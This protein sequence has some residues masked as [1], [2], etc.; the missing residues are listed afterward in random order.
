MV[1]VR[2]V[3][4][5]YSSASGM[6]RSFA[7]RLG[8]EVFD[9]GDRAVRRSVP[10]GPWVLLTPSYTTGNV[11]NDTIP[12]PVRRFLVHPVARRR[13]VGV[14]GSGNRNFGEHYQAACRQIA[15]ASGRPVLFEFELQGTT[16]D[17]EEARRVLEELDLAL[18]LAHARRRT[19]AQA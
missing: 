11:D 13:L 4:Y 14:M 1:P 9:L 2:T 12:E 15:R 17:V 5:Y 10:E 19:G 18:D 3:V 8:R 7:L 6:V 16:W